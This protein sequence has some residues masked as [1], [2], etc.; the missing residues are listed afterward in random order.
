MP[1]SGVATGAFA[2]ALAALGPAAAQAQ[3]PAAPLPAAAV[4]QALAMLSEAARAL[5]PAGARVLAVPGQPDP[6]LKLAPCA[7]VEA[8]LVPGAPAWGRT[9][10]GLRCQKTSD[11]APTPRWSISLPAT[12]QVWA[13]AA[14]S[15]AAL[16]VGATLQADSLALAEVDWAAAPQPPFAH[17]SQLAGRVTA[18][19]VP[20]GQALR[21]TDLQARQWFAA[22][23]TVRVVAGGPGFSISTM[24]QAVSAGIEGQRVRVRVG[25]NRTE[26]GRALGPRM[27]EGRAIGP[28]EVEVGP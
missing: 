25:E 18:R 13:Q 3:E 23:D 28:R 22:G 6:R 7:Q 1:W 2:L 4:A 24:G 9:R 26:D 15:A 17:P 20:A 16:P 27:V 14:V 11:A 21:A 19:P 5:A 10:I 12:V 8:F